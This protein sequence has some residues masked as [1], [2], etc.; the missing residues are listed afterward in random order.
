M[1]KALDRSGILKKNIEIKSLVNYFEDTRWSMDFQ[2]NEVQELSHC[3]TLYQANKNSYLMLEGEVEEAYLCF[4]LKGSV[5]IQMKNPNEEGIKSVT[6][7][8][9]ERTLNIVGPGNI[10]G[11]ISF[12]DNSPRS[13]S[14]IAT[15]PVL[16]LVFDEDNFDWLIRKNPVL[17]VKVMRKISTTVCHRLRQSNNQLI[18]MMTTHDSI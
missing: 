12:L 4:I 1:K 16:F 18:N 8:L 6:P 3:M 10:I 11:E 7:T 13:A 17:S 14:V 5:K 9:S 2:F 15:E